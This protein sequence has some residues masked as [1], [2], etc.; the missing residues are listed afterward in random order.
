MKWAAEVLP[1]AWAAEVCYMQ[2]HLRVPFQTPSSY[3][4]VQKL[5]CEAL[6]RHCAC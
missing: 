1:V 6:R 3:L 4:P 2:Q 5:V